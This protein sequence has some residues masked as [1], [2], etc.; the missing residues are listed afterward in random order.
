MPAEPLRTIRSFAHRA[1]RRSPP[2]QQAFDALWARFGRDMPVRAC[3]PQ[4]WFDR[5]APLT[6]EIGFGRGEA[7]LQEAAD[8]PQRNVL[9]IEVH[10]PALLHTMRA[11]DRLDLRNV[12]IVAGDAAEL[13]PR[14][15]DGCCRQ[16]RILFPDPWPKRRHRKRRLIQDG[17]AAA[18]AR[19]TEPG[20][21]LHV[22]TDWAGYADQIEQVLQCSPDWQPGGDPP[23]RPETHFER[24]GRRLGHAVR[25]WAARRRGSD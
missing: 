19:C 24:R 13:L 3:D 4:A 7:L 10:P 2:Q 12:R 17:F 25:E 21:V 23:P 11:A 6:L 1:R 9:G 15:P 22:A 18:C 8:C 14:L 5:A 20:G 16:I